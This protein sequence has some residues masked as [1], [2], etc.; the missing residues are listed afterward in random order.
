VLVRVGIVASLAGF[1]LLAASGPGYRLHL[2]PLIPALLGAA[3]G[4]VLCLLAFV[5]GGI[6]WL[7]ARRAARPQSRGST[8]ILGLAALVSVF[9]VV[10]LVRARGAP[11]IHDIT[12]DF[13]DPPSF[14]AVLEARWASGAQNT[15]YYRRMQDMGGK[16]L[17]V[18]AAQRGA[19][20][21]I[22]PVDSSEAPAMLMPLAE[23][24]ARAMGWKI[25]A[26]DPAD[27]RLEATDTTRYFGFK[28][29]VVVRIRA[30]PSGSRI[31]VRSE[32]RVGLGDAGANAHRVSAYLARLRELIAQAPTAH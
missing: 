31:D 8:F 26:I 15:P 10:F 18:A 9:A 25:V 13:D 23:K 3:L 20:P 1:V 28:D 19:Y 5:I 17:D 4:F 11:P 27:G 6:G 24:A 29:D 7:A 14:S 16:M 21:G 32:S 30:T 22:L 12:T 2:L